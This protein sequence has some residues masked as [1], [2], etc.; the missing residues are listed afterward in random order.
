VEPERIQRFWD[1]VL[2]REETECWQWTAATNSKGY[3]CFSIAP[4]K[5]ALAHKI[6]WALAKNNGILSDPKD[7]IMHSCDVRTCVNP[8]HLSLG[9]ATD[10]NRD[11]R[12]KGRARNPIHSQNP[13]CRNGH[14]RTP[15]NTHPKYR[16]CIICRR[17]SAREGKRRQRENQREAYN[18]Y[19]R[20]YQRSRKESAE[21]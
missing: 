5:I 1:K 16:T 17:D 3:G 15:E 14:P 9:T 2:V 21:K 7:H 20:A 6:S 10:N 8:A 19:H 11:A 4:G 12:E 13:E 18:A